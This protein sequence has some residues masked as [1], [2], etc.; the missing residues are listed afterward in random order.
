MVIPLLDGREAHL[1]YLMVR[2]EGG[3]IAGLFHNVSY[4]IQISQKYI[5]QTK[6]STLG[7]FKRGCF[8]VAV[9]CASATRCRQGVDILS[10]M[11]TKP[12]LLPRQRLRHTVAFVVWLGRT[13][14]LWVTILWG[15]IGYIK[16]YNMMLYDV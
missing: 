9:P 3:C 8:L 16:P 13:W 4:R 12:A 14:F 5:L 15:I 1:L 11:V 2:D 7:I 10:D 6:N